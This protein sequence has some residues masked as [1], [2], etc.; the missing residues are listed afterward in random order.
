MEGE[1]AYRVNF[2]LSEKADVL[3]KNQRFKCWFLPRFEP[4]LSPWSRPEMN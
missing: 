4:S 2:T 1:H 3:E